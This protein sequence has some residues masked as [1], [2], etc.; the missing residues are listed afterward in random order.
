MDLGQW[1]AQNGTPVV[2]AVALLGLVLLTSLVATLRTKR[3]RRLAH[4]RHTSLFVNN[5]A[6]VAAV[7]PKGAIER[8]NPAFTEMS[9]YDEAQLRG[10]AFAS[11]IAPDDRARVVE[12]LKDD[13]EHRP[14]SVESRL[15]HRD[16]LEVELEITSVPIAIGDR[17]FG[18]YQ[19]ARDLTKQREMERELE[20][21]ALHDHLTG[22]ANRSLFSDRIR[23]ALQ[24]V[25]RS[26]HRVALLYMDLDRFKLVN[27]NAGHAGGDVLLCEVA[28]RLRNFVREGDTVARLGGDEFA[29]LLEDVAD[30]EEADTAAERLVDLINEPFKVN[31]KAAYV[32]AS[33]G[34]AVSTPEL[35]SPEQLVRRADKAMYEA[36]RRGGYRY[37]PYTSEMDTGGIRLGDHLE[38]EL[39]RGL[40]AG[41]LAVRYQP[42]VDL[43]GTQIVGV[44]ALVRWN[45]PV[46]GL[47]PP[48]SFIPVAENA[49]IIVQLDRWVL[50]HSCRDIRRLLKQGV[51]QSRPFTLSV[52]LSSQHFEDDGLVD[53][54]YDIL[55]AEQF[56]AEYLQLE[57]KEDVVATGAE[58]IARLKSL[59]VTVAIDDF[60]MG[61][62]PLG[63]LRDAMID[64]LKVDRTF[65][66]ALGG[67][68]ISTAVIRTILS[69]AEM[70]GL[71]VVI[72]GIEDPV[73]IE[74]LR[75]L[76]GRL[77]QGFYF[78]APVEI[79]ELEHL[80]TRGLAPAFIYQPGR[81]APAQEAPP[82]AV[83]R[84]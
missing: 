46:H 14:H 63:Y 53:A 1:V 82:E 38:A 36:K 8:V 48:S 55:T 4:E 22:L 37:V 79:D 58:K 42:V 70:H 12:S 27:D 84:G 33:V 65:V 39:R 3:S 7:D 16:G 17:T 11:L 21:R 74:A 73:Q 83:G 6:A 10:I 25:R 68:R 19:I 31:G 44:E 23:H 30:Q 20:S 71:Q 26:G 45:H 5:T 43:A 64:V 76:G 61:D 24:R 57:I 32:G 15:V 77:V 50:E 78:V 60:G 35:E 29:I 34:V 72:E 9:G 51:I 41:E 2:A 81:R 59:G 18:T 28:A 52:N 49:G 80:L 66:M 54:V 13:S 75:Q 69:L 56:A 62:E 40:A 67:D 47:L